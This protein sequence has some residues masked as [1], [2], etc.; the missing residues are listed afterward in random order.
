MTALIAADGL[1]VR[2]EW[3]LLVD[4]PA[5]EVAPGE[6]LV[7]L[8]PTGAGK[9]TLL[10]A[11]GLLRKPSAGCI[12]WLGEALPW[13]APL[14]ARR[15]MA[16]VFQDPLLFGGTVRE[17]VTYGLRLRGLPGPEIA[18][19]A[20]SVMAM[21][22]IDHLA[23][24]TAATLSGGEAQRTA[25]ARALAVAPDLLLLDEPLANLDAPI[26]E[27]LVPDLKA[28]LRA[29]KLTCVFVTHHQREALAL[30]DRIAVLHQG[31][32]EQVDAPGTVFRRPA[33][34][35]V[36]R[37]VGTPNLWPGRIVGRNGALAEVAVAGLHLFAVSALPVG[38]E[39]QAC[40]RPEAV[41]LGTATG[42]NSWEATVGAVQDQGSTLRF[43]LDGPL[44]LKALGLPSDPRLQGLAPG[45]RITVTI[46]PEHLHLIAEG[47]AQAAPSLDPAVQSANSEG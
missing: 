34:P 19:R 37:F 33:T 21:L 32:L 17:N 6:V 25:L 42:P 7:I 14:A 11:L 38:A 45:Q 28:A 5:L 36:A 26:R 43:H 44:P 16:M 20:G 18:E 35:F 24:R 27:R 4:V 12:R 3:R 23:D 8:G 39:V 22:H 40:L 31:R 47:A 1:Q 10:Q 46:A 29:L 2:A 30:A 15:R 13:P 9:S 41:A